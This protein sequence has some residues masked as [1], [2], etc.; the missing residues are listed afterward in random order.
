LV[1]IHAAGLG[2]IESAKLA[3][4]LGLLVTVLAILRLA[5][6]L[7]A[8]GPCQRWFSDPRATL[9]WAKENGARYFIGGQ[10]PPEPGAAP[11]F[12]TSV[13]YLGWT[14]NRSQYRTSEPLVLYKLP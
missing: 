3:C 7:V 2:W 10:R 6:D 13:P 5:H 8:A 11:V 14:F 4:A 9:R 12:A 1:V